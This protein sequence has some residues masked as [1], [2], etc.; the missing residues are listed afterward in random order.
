M[1]VDI[2]RTRRDYQRTPPTAQERRAGRQIIAGIIG[3]TLCLAAYGAASDNAAIIVSG[4]LS[5]VLLALVM[6]L[7]KPE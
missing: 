4:S 2:V 5:A 3:L 7:S 6:A 1:T